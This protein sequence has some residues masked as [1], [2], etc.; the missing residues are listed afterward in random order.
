VKLIKN[1]LDAGH[2][3][4]AH[5]ESSGYRPLHCAASNNHIPAVR[6]LLETG[7][8]INGRIGYGGTDRALDVAAERGHAAVVKFLIGQGAAIN[9]ASGCPALT[10]AAGKKNHKLVELLLR[11]GAGFEPSLLPKAIYTGDVKL[12]D[13]LIQ[14]GAKVV[15]NGDKID[16][17][18]L[19]RATGQTRGSEMIELIANHGADLKWR[20]K[21]D[22][23]TT[24]HRA[25]CDDTALFLIANGADIQ[26]VDNSGETPLHSCAQRGFVRACRRLLELGADPRAKSRSG[27]TPRMVAKLYGEQ[28]T[29]DL[30]T[31][32]LKQAKPAKTPQRA[33]MAEATRPTENSTKHS[34]AF[35]IQKPTWK[36]ISNCAS[37]FI[38][39]VEG[40]FPEFAV[41]AVRATC[42]EVV[43]EGKVLWP[44]ESWQRRV[45]IKPTEES[46]SQCS[47][48]GLIE[49]R[50]NPWTMIMV[51]MGACDIANMTTWAAEL[52]KKLKTTAVDFCEGDGGYQLCVHSMG[53]LQECLTWCSGTIDHFKSEYRKRPKLP[54]NDAEIADQL[55]GEHGIYFAPC[56]PCEL[57]TKKLGLAVSVEARHLILRADLLDPGRLG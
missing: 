40:S 53:K 14:A 47:T 51:S 23:E 37:A 41:M 12:V 20:S 54:K 49:I 48:F 52:S 44:Q 8:D 11:H 22:G 34:S 21:S 3:P 43:K 31:E 17:E 30:I 25:G 26:A 7:A 38:N 2:D 28:G 42:S 33:K 16:P 32:A 13:R 5:N 1:F 55:I 9:T 36:L 15:G 27:Y 29:Y 18:I 46:D 35:K 56:Y 50:D 4:N 39:L 45:N 57:G 19:L 6:L 10:E 24:L